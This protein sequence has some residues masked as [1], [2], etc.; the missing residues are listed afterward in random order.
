MVI[1]FT[2]MQVRNPNFF[3]TLDLNDNGQLRSVFWIHPRSRLSCTYFGD[4]L[5]FDSTYLT[6]RYQMP[7]CPF[8]GVNH[9]GQSTLLGCALLSDERTE[10][11]KWVFQSWLDANGGQ[12]PK[13]MVTD[14]DK[15]IEAAVREVFPNAR[16]R[17]CLWHILKKIPEK[18]G[19]I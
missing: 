13:A 7:F 9:H 4:V 1:H 6:N 17:F 11:Y 3:Y 2:K 14:Q 16:H 10:T 18:I 8:V 15:A 12:A 5:S 19:H